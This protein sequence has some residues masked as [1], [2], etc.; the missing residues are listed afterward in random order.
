MEATL[1][2]L[3]R[4]CGEHYD[5]CTAAALGG[6]DIECAVR[7]IA[8]ANHLDASP[9]RSSLPEVFFQ[10]FDT[11]RKQCRALLE[12][13]DTPDSIR[14]GAEAVARLEAA[15]S[16]GLDSS[17]EGRRSMMGIDAA[18]RAIPHPL[19]GEHRELLLKGH[20][21]LAVALIF[22]FVTCGNT[23]ATPAAAP[24]TYD[25]TPAAAAGMVFVHAAFIAYL[26][27]GWA[28]APDALALRGFAHHARS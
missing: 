23:P 4:Q 28:Q 22:E 13:N 19:K 5:L 18:L 6:T 14:R 9:R 15:L 24:A 10:S 16:R 11:K 1:A 2:E 17:I 21:K 20:F 7:F 12:V 8:L 27:G 3:Q 25:N 26:N